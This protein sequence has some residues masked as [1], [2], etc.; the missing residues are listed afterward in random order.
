[1]TQYV[2]IATDAATHVTI[3]GDCKDLKDAL[4]DLATLGWTPDAKT[5]ASATITYEKQ[6]A[7]RKSTG[8]ADKAPAENPATPLDA[9]KAAVEGDP[10]ALTAEQEAAM[11]AGHTVAFTKAQVAKMVADA[12]AAKADTP[13][14]TYEKDVGPLIARAQAKDRAKTVAVLT[15]NGGVN[16]ETGK[17]SGPALKPE[18]WP[19]VIAA[20]DAIL[21]G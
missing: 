2:F 14:L 7:A 6:D 1:M 16:P 17:P 15:G 13:P 20:L 3:T 9:L 12:E 21:A 4:A 10:T 19:A 11:A 18:T 5:T 8:K